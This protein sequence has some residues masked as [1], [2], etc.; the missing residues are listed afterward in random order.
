MA[1]GLAKRG[2]SVG[3]GRPTTGGAVRHKHQGI[4][5]S[6]CQNA[7]MSMSCYPLTN[8]QRSNLL[9]FT[10]AAVYNQGL[11]TDSEIEMRQTC[12]LREELPR[13]SKD[14]AGLRCCG[15]K[16]LASTSRFSS[17]LVALF[18]HMN[19]LHSLQ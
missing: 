10:S 18:Q 8:A 5:R 16:W 1:R 14:E 12:A 3:Q 4:S 15:R 7:A 6:C 19:E 9:V 11:E 17:S 2:G 13:D